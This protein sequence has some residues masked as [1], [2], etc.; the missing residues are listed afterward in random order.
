[1]W[2]SQGSAVENSHLLGCYTIS[3]GSSWHL[4]GMQ[5][6][7]NLG[8]LFN[9]QHAIT[10]PKTQIFGF[11]IITITPST[12]TMTNLFTESNL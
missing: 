3:T 10:S 8:G 2:G 5:W 7:K 11:S 6:L 4:K 9:N 12:M 1:M